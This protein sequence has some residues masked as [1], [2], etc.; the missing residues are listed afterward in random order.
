[1]A[2]TRCFLQCWSETAGVPESMGCDSAIQ[3]LTRRFDAHGMQINNGVYRSG[4]A[5]TQ[6]A[7]E[8]A[9]ADLYAALDAVEQRLGA[10]RFLVG[11]R[12]VAFLCA[13]CIAAHAMRTSCMRVHVVSTR[14]LP[15][16]C[17]VIVLYM[18]S[19][20]CPCFRC[21][22]CECGLLVCMVRGDP[23]GP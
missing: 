5:T 2:Y 20:Q 21:R 4:F 3:A 10:H 16:T 1:M 9:Q 7:Y 15:G 18:A 11:D 13:R 23:L 22:N 14:S 19:Q 12:S 6:A 17:K 8:R